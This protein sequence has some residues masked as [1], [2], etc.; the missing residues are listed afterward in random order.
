MSYHL[1][2]LKKILIFLFY[3]LVIG[4]FLQALG[5]VLLFCKKIRSGVVLTTAGFLVLMLFSYRPLM[6][7]LVSSYE[8][9][10][11]VLS[12][13]EKLKDVE[14]IVVLGGG[15]TPDERLTA[16][17]QLSWSSLSRLIEGIR[18]LRLLPSAR[19]LVS[20]GRVFSDISEAGLMK[21]AAME[22]GADENRIVLED[23]SRDTGDQAQKLKKVLG[24]K[25][26]VLVTSAFHMKRAVY[27]FEKIGMH[28][29]P[30]PA[31]FQVK[32]K[33]YIDPGLFFP[34]PESLGRAQRNLKE[35]LALI[36]MR[37][38]NR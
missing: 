37:V 34:S 23:K 29:V 5:L 19:L 32:I 15:V 38:T 3:P 25:P 26:F 20:G 4:L 24:E 12:E 28:P 7:P 22:I 13:V 36:L 2:L 33:E 9:V 11:P 21:R 10:F 35:I 17:N 8:S 30:A 14:W 1:F 31:D 16:A 6:D 18:I 27:D